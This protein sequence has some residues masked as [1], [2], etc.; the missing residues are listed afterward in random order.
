MGVASRYRISP[1]QGFFINHIAHAAT[2]SRYGKVKHKYYHRIAGSVFSEADLLVGH[3]LLEEAT[4]FHLRFRKV[5][6][7]GI[8]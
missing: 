3:T 5:G 8:R 4:K 2:L 1:F 6:K 7:Y